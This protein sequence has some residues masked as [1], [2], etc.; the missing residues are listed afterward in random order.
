MKIKQKVFNI[1]LLIFLLI[2]YFS[3]LSFAQDVKLQILKGP[4]LQN[5]TQNSIVIM[6]ETNIETI[7]KVNYGLDKNYDATAVEEGNKKIHEIKLTNLKTETLY[8]YQI[9]TGNITSEDNTFKTAPNF[10]TPFKFSVWGDNR[11]FFFEHAKVIRKMRKYNPDIAINVGDVVTNGNVYEQWERE[12]FTPA[13]ELFKNVPSFIAIGN[14]ENNAHWFY[15]FVSQ[16]NNEDWFYFIY[17]NSMFIILDSN[18]SYQPSSEQLLW[19]RK[20]LK[21]EDYKKTKWHFVFMHHPLYSEGWDSPGYDG[22]PLARLILQPIF[23]KYKI[24]IFFAGHTHDYE[25]GMLNGVYYIITGGGGAGLDSKQQDF[26][27]ITVYKAEHQFCLVDI[28]KN[29]LSFKS[30]NV[31]GKEIDNFK[32]EK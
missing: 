18:K 23:E 22:E 16:P 29:K 2:F 9:V 31:E 1:N 19:L 21:S 32:I 25:R 11:T 15:D 14:H 26:P 27:F 3:S 10:D 13:K 5:V 28:N 6:W 30:I 8:H 20:T 7:G 17:G 12:Y 4:Y 24:D